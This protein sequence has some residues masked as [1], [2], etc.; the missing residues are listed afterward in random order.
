MFIVQEE[1]FGREDWKKGTEEKE[2][3][4]EEEKEKE[5]EKEKEEE[6]EQEKE[7]KWGRTTED[8]LRRKYE[9]KSG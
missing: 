6:K 4:K 5:K 3:E 8:S 7:K 1:K 2:K 9:Q